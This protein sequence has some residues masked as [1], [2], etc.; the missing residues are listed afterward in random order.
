MIHPIDEGILGKKAVPML[1]IMLVLLQLCMPFHCI[2]VLL[3]NIPRDTFAVQHG[4]HIFHSR[5]GLHGSL[6]WCRAMLNES[7]ARELFLQTF[8]Q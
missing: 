3:F 1:P 5:I 8:Y 6:P 7:T 2:C 4:N